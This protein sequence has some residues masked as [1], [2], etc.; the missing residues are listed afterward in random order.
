MKTLFAGNLPFNTTDSAVVPVV[1]GMISVPAVQ[2]KTS[3]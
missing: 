1:I 3:L 2:V